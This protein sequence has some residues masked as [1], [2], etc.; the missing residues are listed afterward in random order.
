VFNERRKNKIKAAKWGAVLSY[1]LMDVFHTAKRFFEI[2]PKEKWKEYMGDLDR[3]HTIPYLKT[4]VESDLKEIEK[5]YNVFREI[6]N[7]P[8][9]YNTILN[10]K[11]ISDV[12]VILTT[13]PEER[14]FL[15]G[16]Y[17][18]ERAFLTALTDE[19]SPERKGF[20]KYYFDQF[21]VR[22]IPHEYKKINFKE[23]EDYY[24]KTKKEFNKKIFDNL[25][26]A[27]KF[28]I[29]NSTDKNKK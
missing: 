13:S 12:D 2:T 11:H 20:Q 29:E 17:A 23:K 5:T 24:E 6:M 1:T 19:K 4:K 27:D 14:K 28:L 9:D 22:I 15:I 16:L 21:R 7:N 18:F 3:K 10:K 8:K 25:D 26:E